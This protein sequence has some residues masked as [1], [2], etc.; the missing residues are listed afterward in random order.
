MKAAALLS[1]GQGG[2]P[3]KIMQ[4][5]HGDAAPCGRSGKIFGVRRVWIS[6]R[7]RWVL[8]TADTV[9]F[10]RGMRVALCAR[11]QQGSLFHVFKEYTLGGPGTIKVEVSHA[12]A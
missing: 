8:G 1:G 6:M 12:S 7:Y 11:L 5:L 9:L 4:G 10:C 2:V 3:L